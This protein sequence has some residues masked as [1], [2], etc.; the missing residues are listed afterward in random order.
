[1]A[2]TTNRMASNAETVVL[3]GGLAVPVEALCVLWDLESRGLQI[4]LT[5]A[6]RIRVSPGDWLTDEDAAAIAMYRR[7][8]RPQCPR[9]RTITVVAPL[10]AHAP[11]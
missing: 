9:Q 11:H 6:G 1:M 2:A 10:R 8:A 4:R 7:H 3:S 5:T